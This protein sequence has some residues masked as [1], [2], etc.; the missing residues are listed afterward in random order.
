MKKEQRE[1]LKR[2]VGHTK[3]G[4][5]PGGLGYTVFKAGSFV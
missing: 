2:E 1:H 3:G 5:G 4:N